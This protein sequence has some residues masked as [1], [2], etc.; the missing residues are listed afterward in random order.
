MILLDFRSSAAS[1]TE[2]HAYGQ[3]RSRSCR[4]RLWTVID[5][6]TLYLHPPN[7]PGS[8]GRARGDAGEAPAGPEAD[9]QKIALFSKFL[10]ILLHEV[11]SLVSGLKWRSVVKRRKISLSGA[12]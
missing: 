1:G 5:A 8:I 10:K 12:V 11:F 2:M 3:G 4:H 7:P 6:N 9:F